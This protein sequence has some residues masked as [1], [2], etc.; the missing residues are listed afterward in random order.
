MRLLLDES[1]PRRFALLLPDHEVKTVVQ[2]GWGGTKNGAL[3]SLA[4]RE[5]DVFITVDANLPYQQN[6]AALPIAVVVLKALS[7]ELVNLIPLIPEL[8]KAL[9]RLQP[10]QFVSVEMPTGTSGAR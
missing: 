7:N 9:A 3:L 5:F 10:G 8:E 2:V 6:I 4:G 1:V